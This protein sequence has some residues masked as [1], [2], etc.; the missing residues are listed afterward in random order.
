M[1]L[2]LGLVRGI[3]ADKRELFLLTPLTVDKMQKVKMLVIS[4][5]ETP[6]EIFLNQRVVGQVP[7]VVHNKNV[8]ANAPIIRMHRSPKAS[9]HVPQ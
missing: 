7:Y 8:E 3:N 4:N 9:H 5:V 2:V 6:G 1:D